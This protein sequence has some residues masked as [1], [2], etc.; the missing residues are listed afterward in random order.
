MVIK[1][2]N[3]TEYKVKQPNP[4]MKEQEV[5]SDFTL[6][7][8]E[9]DKDLV[10]NEQNAPKLQKPKLKLGIEKTLKKEKEIPLPTPEV[11]IEENDD[12]VIP[13]FNKEENAPDPT[14]VPK[15]DILRP[16]KI[17]QK[18]LQYK[19]DV[20]YCMLAETKEN[21]DPLYSEKT[22]KINYVRTFTFENIIL[23]QNDIQLI[24]WSHLDFLTK[25][26]IVY[27]RD[28]NHRW[29]KINSIRNAPDGRFFVCVPTSIQPSFKG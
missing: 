8:M 12:F 10:A 11:Q 6:H 7:N 2:K 4:I 21:F 18:L 1:N 15:D 16:S 25:N 3:G 17:N 13:D 23:E 26:S 28:E 9:F 29:W 14:P 20:M 22:V 27:P 19:K 5:W 24:F